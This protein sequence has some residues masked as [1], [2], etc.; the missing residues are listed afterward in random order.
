METHDNCHFCG[1]LI[2]LPNRTGIGRPCCLPCK[3]NN[4]TFRKPSNNY[5]QGAYAILRNAE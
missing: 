3:E 1:K 5:A 2:V 4:G